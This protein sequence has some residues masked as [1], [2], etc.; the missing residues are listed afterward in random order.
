M[1]PY[2]KDFKLKVIKHVELE[3]S[4]I[5]IVAELKKIPKQTLYRWVYVYRRFGE[6][7]LENRKPGANETGINPGFE[8]L[9]LQKWKKRKRSAHKLWMDLKMKGYNVAERQI[10]KIYRKHGLK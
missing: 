3:L 9:I 6:K 4:S 5:P 10:Q 2:T 1:M 7:G 8:V